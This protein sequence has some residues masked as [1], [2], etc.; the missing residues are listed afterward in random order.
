MLKNQSLILD[1]VEWISKHPRSYDETMEAWRTSCPR[2][3]IWEDAC[4]QGLVV[5]DHQQGMGTIVRLTESGRQ[6]LHQHRGLP[7]EKGT[8]QTN[9]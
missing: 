9:E 8:N 6:L 4:D 3:P 7:V 5:R 2:L 1:L